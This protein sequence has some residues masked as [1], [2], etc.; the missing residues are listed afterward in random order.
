MTQERI[1]QIYQMLE[2]WKETDNRERDA[3]KTSVVAEL[4][5]E[6]NCVQPRKTAPQ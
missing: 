6:L 1:K 4:L 2:A 3:E 5:T